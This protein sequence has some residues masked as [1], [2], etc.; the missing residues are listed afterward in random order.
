MV[1]DR[2][3]VQR[4]TASNEN[5]D[6][7]HFKICSLFPDTESGRSVLSLLPL[8]HQPRKPQDCLSILHKAPGPWQL[9]VLP[10]DVQN[11]ALLAAQI[12]SASTVPH[13]HSS[14]VQL[15]WDRERIKGALMSPAKT[16]AKAFPYTLDSSPQEK[17]VTYTTSELKHH[18]V[19]PNMCQIFS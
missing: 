14:N 19:P 8:P 11:S 4:K 6:I 18:I 9:L 1:D 7:K 3:S 2:Q 16:P 12:C 15:R 5:S 13:L 10:L 17:N